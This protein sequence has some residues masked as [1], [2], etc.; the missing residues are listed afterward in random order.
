MKMRFHKILAVLFTLVLCLH[1][2]SMLSAQSDEPLPL[3]VEPSSIAFQNRATVELLTN[4]GFE[5]DADG[6]RLPDGWK[7]KH[8]DLAKSDRLK[9]STSEAIAYTGQC[10]FMF[11][12]NS[13]GV[14]SRLTQ[15]IINS[16][17]IINGSTLT[18][19]AFISSKHAETNQKI[20]SV[21]VKFSDGSR[22]K[23]DLR[24][25]AAAANAYTQHT[26]AALVTIPARAV[27][28]NAKLDLSYG[29]ASGRYL[30]DDVSLI[31]TSEIS[32]STSTPV[33]PTNTPSVETSATSTSTDSTDGTAVPTF[34]ATSTGT[35]TE[36]SSA[37][38]TPA[39]TVEVTPSLDY[40]ATFVVTATSTASPTNTPTATPTN[41]PT[42]TLTNVPPAITQLLAD[43]GDFGDY[44]GYSV[45]LSLDGNTALVGAAGDDVDGKRDQG[46][47]YVYIRSGNGWVQQAHL[48]ASDGAEGDWLG[49]AVSLSADGNTALIGA[50]FKQV[51]SNAVQGAAYVYTRVGNIWTEQAKLTAFGGAVE[52]RFGYAVTL[53][54]DGN[55]AFVGVPQGDVD[56]NINQGS[57]Y[58]YTQT[59]NTWLMHLQFFAVDGAS[60][61][62]F[63][64]TLSL[65]D[66]GNTLAVGA[67]Q[68]NVG[69]NSDQGSVY[70]YRLNGN[71]WPQ[72][73]KL[74]AADGAVNDWFGYAVSLNSDGTRVIVS[75]YLDDTNGNNNQ[76]SAYIFTRSGNT[77]TQ[78]A[79]LLADDGA[80]EDYFGRAVSITG[81][82]NRV[83]VTAH[84]ND[85]G[86]NE[87]QGSAYLYTRSGNSWTQQ[88]EFAAP[89]SA[90]EDS[91]GS[92]ADMSADGKTV[93]IGVNSDDIGDNMVQ[94]SAWVFPLP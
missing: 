63:G 45:S 33:P 18:L 14:E 4:S 36:I 60:N 19:S 75:A 31:V 94:G 73:A 84:L 10:A 65:S 23:L 67:Y 70:I 1:I 53:S 26:A 41:T 22:L 55:T 71:V 92:A 62:G 78:E 59:G 77:W 90:A 39:S 64:H 49:Q 6:N 82:G 52:D 61:D 69:A 79:K 58:I 21:K 91:F 38:K 86:L 17:S 76:G 57:V 83:V 40:T 30:V 5:I 42:A 43:D 32:V 34:T 54:A 11:R 29:G 81:D 2:F 20:A 72:Q 27:I 80:V 88:Q 51:G 25:L 28:T 89:D 16:D 37:T 47:A 13:N 7:G 46:S 12:G 24:L 44:F 56:T 9:C 50:P 35:A 87:Y 93:I 85:V 8:T 66:D 15:T 48:L 3:P 74:T 68:D